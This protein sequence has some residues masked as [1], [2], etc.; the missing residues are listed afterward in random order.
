MTRDSLHRRLTRLLKKTASAASLP[1]AAWWAGDIAG[2]RRVLDDGE[3]GRLNWAAANRVAQSGLEALA[4]G[5]L[6][7]AEVCAWAATDHYVAAL[8]ARVRPSAIEDLAKKTKRRG[9]PP[10]ITDR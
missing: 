10:K 5:N 4:D 9:R 3:S 7:M 1:P 2:E 8:E 6:E